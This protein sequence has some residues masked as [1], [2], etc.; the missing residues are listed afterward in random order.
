MRGHSA[1]LS[2]LV[3]RWQPETHTFH[4]PV[5]EVTVT[6]E[7]VIH[8][9]GLQVNGEPVTGR[10]DSSYQFLVD[11][12]IAC[13][14]RQPGPDDHVL[15]K[16]GAASLAHL[17]RSL[18][19]ASRYNCKEMDGPLI[20]L[21]VWVWERMPFMAPIPRNELLDVGVPLARQWSH[22]RRHTRYTRR[23]TAQFRRG[24]DDMGV[25]DFTWRPYV[26]VDVRQD[27]GPNLF[28][29]STK[30]P[31]VSFE[32]IEWHPTDRVRRQFGLQQLPPDPKFQIG[33]AH[34]KLMVSVA[35]RRGVE[36]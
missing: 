20:L 21:F 1:L 4:L 24:L 23:S 3:E 31:L 9:L 22:W 25:N 12:C 2:A 28:M 16:L 10:L 26:G 29:C 11:N 5:G 15:G 18:C 8:I 35:K 17:Y 34:C 33:S 30:S 36:S 32:C 19:R 6:L 7:D 13:F 27:L 14:G